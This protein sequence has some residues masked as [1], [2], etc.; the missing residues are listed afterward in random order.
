MKDNWIAILKDARSRIDDWIK[1]NPKERFAGEVERVVYDLLKRAND[2]VGA[3]LCLNNNRYSETAMGLARVTIELLV[4]I[5]MIKNDPENIKYL[6]E[7][8]ARSTKKIFELTKDAH[9]Q[10]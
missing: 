6:K 5:M 1:S 10:P 4:D 9:I 2:N 8:Q 3:I 7:S